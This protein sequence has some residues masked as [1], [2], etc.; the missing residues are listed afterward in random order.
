MS[1]PKKVRPEAVLRN[2]PED[3]QR[4]IME[5]MEVARIEEVVKRKHADNTT[6]EFTRLRPPT[7][8]E[9]IDWLRQ[10]GI[11]TSSGALSGWRSWYLLNRQMAANEAAA[12]ALVE[13][14]K[15]D[16]WIKT[17]DEEQAC[18]QAFFNRLAMANQDPK[19]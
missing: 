3:R 18:A 10:D 5:Y 13:Q 8:S 15:A 6:E 7:L 1:I 16:G 9:T 14:G 11:V 17:S 19:Q 2:L 12:E 4:A